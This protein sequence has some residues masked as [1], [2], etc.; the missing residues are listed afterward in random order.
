[1]TISGMLKMG[2]YGTEREVALR[3]SPTAEKIEDKAAVG[4]VNVR[5]HGCGGFNARLEMTTKKARDFANQILR[6]ANEAEEAAREIDR[7]R[8]EEESRT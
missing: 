7:R 4:F 6:E 8:A 5:L 3:V 1:M 2:A